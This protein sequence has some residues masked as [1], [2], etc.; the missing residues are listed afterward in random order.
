V[1]GYD[2]TAR[3]MMIVDRAGIDIT[4]KAI[5]RDRADVRANSGDPEFR[6]W[7]ARRERA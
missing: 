6:K 7:L 1:I 2:D 4:Q 3:A 5:W